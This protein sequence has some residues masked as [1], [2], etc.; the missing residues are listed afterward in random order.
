[1]SEVTSKSAREASF[2]SVFIERLKSWVVYSEP[3]V[4]F[5]FSVFRLLKR[6]GLWQFVIS[7]R[8]LS[9]TNRARQIVPF[10]VCGNSSTRWLDCISRYRFCWPEDQVLKMWRLSAFLR[11]CITTSLS[12]HSKK[13]KLAQTTGLDSDLNSEQPCPNFM[14]LCNSSSE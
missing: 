14:F 7:A 1:M 5:T 2:L 6:A 3:C 9:Q 11:R 8:L 13:G 12:T 4:G 10:E